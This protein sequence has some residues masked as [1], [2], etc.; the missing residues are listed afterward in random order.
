M[1]DRRRF[2]QSSVALGAA[3]ATWSASGAETSAGGAPRI[4]VVDRQLA[5][6]AAFLFERRS[7]GLAAFEFAGDPAALWMRELE[8]RLRSGALVIEGY[9]SAATAFCLEYLARDYGAS[10]VRRE[11][12]AGTVTWILSSSPARRAALA[13]I[14]PRGSAFH[15]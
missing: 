8:P 15:A 9:T 13:P 14:D 12:A 1:I 3:V 10:A 2:M 11:E 7:R 5:G 4:V 6:S